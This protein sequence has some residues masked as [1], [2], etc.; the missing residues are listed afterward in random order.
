MDWDDVIGAT[1]G[2]AIGIAAI[3]GITY[4]WSSDYPIAKINDVK[5]IVAKSEDGL[6]ERYGVVQVSYPDGS[7][8]IFTTRWEA[9]SRGESCDEKSQTLVDKLNQ[10]KNSGQNVAIAVGG[11]RIP[12][13][14]AMTPWIEGVS[15]PVKISKQ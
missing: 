4:M 8:R 7:S 11:D 2:A 14:W 10:A 1:I 5:E 6:K 13:R 9:C 15:E 3:E 12:S